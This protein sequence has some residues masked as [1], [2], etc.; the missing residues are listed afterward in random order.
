[1]SGQALLV[2][3]LWPQLEVGS[4][5]GHPAH[6]MPFPSTVWLRCLEAESFDKGLLQ[7]M[8]QVQ[9]KSNCCVLALIFMPPEG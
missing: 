4:C 1:M 3:R 9:R 6:S 2:V 8:F 7:L 5:I